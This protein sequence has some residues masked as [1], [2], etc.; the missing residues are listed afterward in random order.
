M[1]T[2]NLNGMIVTQEANLYKMYLPNWTPA[3]EALAPLDNRSDIDF[4]LVCSI[5]DL[6]TKQQ[7]L[8]AVN[9]NR[10]KK[11]RIP[12]NMVIWRGAGEYKI[13]LG[14]D[15][16]TGMQI[17]YLQLPNDLITGQIVIAIAILMQRRWAGFIQQQTV[18]SQVR[19]T[20]LQAA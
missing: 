6:L 13:Y 5:T 14:K 7:G 17:G 2:I 18:I 20:N 12:E 10:F 4:D 15:I 1:Y 9:L 3:M 19:H 16:L 8:S 11:L